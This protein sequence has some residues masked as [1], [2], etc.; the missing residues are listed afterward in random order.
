MKLAKRFLPLVLIAAFAFVVACGDDDVAATP[1]VNVTG[2][3][4]AA[5][6]ILARGGTATAH[7]GGSAGGA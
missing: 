3:A 6:G 4:E 7:A 1:T 2:T 5:A